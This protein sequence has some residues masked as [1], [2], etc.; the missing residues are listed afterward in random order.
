MTNFFDTPAVARNLLATEG[1]L[2]PS[3][4]EVHQKMGKVIADATIPYRFKGDLN[5]SIRKIALNLVLFPR[6]H[7]LE[8]YQSK[9]K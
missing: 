8:F 6:M 3:K 5:T 4:E 1:R 9:H 7:F 2:R